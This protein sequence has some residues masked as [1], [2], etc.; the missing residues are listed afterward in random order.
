M[1]E[2]GRGFDYRKEWDARDTEKKFDNC[3]R[4]GMWDFDTGLDGGILTC[5]HAVIRKI[6]P[7][8]TYPA[9]F[10]REIL[11]NDTAEIVYFFNSQASR[12]DYISGRFFGLPIDAKTLA[13]MEKNI[14]VS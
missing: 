13:S 10:F 12:D 14:K 8:N 6:S 7:N 4:A 2:E 11:G 5:T 9:Y 3:V 1:A